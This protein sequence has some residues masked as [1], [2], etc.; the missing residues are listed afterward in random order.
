[1]LH[2]PFLGLR[3]GSGEGIALNL[4]VRYFPEFL[5]VTRL[6]HPNVGPGTQATLAALKHKHCTILGISEFL[7]ASYIDH[8]CELFVKNTYIIY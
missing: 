7:S 5:P 6:F 1:M 3:T 8:I 2:R 4:F